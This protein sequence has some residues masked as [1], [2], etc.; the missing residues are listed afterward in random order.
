MEINLARLAII[1]ILLYYLLSFVSL[2]RSFDFRSR[3]WISPDT[4][5]AKIQNLVQIG[6][7]KRE[8]TTL[9]AVSLFL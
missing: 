6:I 1:S 2:C 5:F 7:A 4:L 8:T 3:G 9:A